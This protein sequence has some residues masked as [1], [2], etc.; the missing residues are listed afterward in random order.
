[1]NPS[2]QH[3]PTAH[4]ITVSTRCASGQQDDRSGPDAGRLL[5]SL[6]LKITGT[7]VIPDDSLKI[8][9]AVLAHCDHKPVSL[10]VFSGGTG[11]TPDDLTPTAIEGLLDRRYE[12]IETAIHDAGRSST[13]RA[14]L[15]RIL[16]GARGDTIVIALPGSPG[17]VRDAITVLEPFLMH[18]LRLSRGETDPH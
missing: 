10:L 17:G 16:T 12:G 18:L 15:S 13:P 1:M 8:T 5:E 3:P 4:I 14:P 9:Q 11:P 7:G 2:E 6:G